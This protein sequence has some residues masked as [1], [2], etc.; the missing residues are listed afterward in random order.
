MLPFCS[1]CRMCLCSAC[2][3]VTESISIHNRCPGLRSLGSCG[4]AVF[5][6]LSQMPRTQRGFGVGQSQPNSLNERERN[7]MHAGFQPSP[8]PISARCSVSAALAWQV[9]IHCRN[10]KVFCPQPP[11]RPWSISAVSGSLGPRSSPD[12]RRRGNTK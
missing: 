3:S 8:I 1:P 2:P 7:R 4:C 11:P 10:A 6:S 9:S 5:A 12:E